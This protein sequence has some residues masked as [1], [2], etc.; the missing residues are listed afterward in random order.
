MA[1]AKQGNVED[2]GALNPNFKGLIANKIQA[3]WT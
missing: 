3:N 1:K 2:L